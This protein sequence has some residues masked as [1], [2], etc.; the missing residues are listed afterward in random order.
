MPLLAVLPPLAVVAYLVVTAE[1]PPPEPSAEDPPV[2]AEVPEAPRDSIDADEPPVPPGLDPDTLMGGIERRG[3]LPDSIGVLL[4][5]T[6]PG[7]EESIEEY[8]LWLP[9]GLERADREWPLLLYLHG[10]SLRGEDTARL[11]RYGLPRYLGEGRS[12]PFIV[13]APQLRPPGGW[14][15]VDRLA[16]LLDEIEARYPVDEDRIYVTGYSM[17]GGGTW[18]MAFAHADRLAAAAPFAAT[19]PR[20]TPERVRAVSGLPLL[21]YHGTADEV[22]PVGRVLDM[23][24]ALREAGADVELELV[25]GADHGDLTTVFGEPALYAWL[26]GHRRE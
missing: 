4:E 12:I 9:P 23:V 10:R 5:R 1:D 19:T 17:G 8:L 25:E 11:L 13:V 2:V 16:A 24:E 26:L 14:T 21:V 15:D 7:A 3:S 6:L 18:R 22:A 20:P